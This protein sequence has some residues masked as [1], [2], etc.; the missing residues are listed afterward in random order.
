MNERNTGVL[1]DFYTE[2]ELAAELGIVRRTLYRWRRMRTGPDVT[3]V[4]ERVMYRRDSVKR[5]LL[6][7]EQKMVRG[8]RTQH[9]EHQVEA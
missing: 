6:S 9:A 3:M 5:W 7:Q 8:R 1:A 2:A 4:G